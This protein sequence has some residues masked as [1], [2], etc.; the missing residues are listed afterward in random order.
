ML[1]GSE[2]NRFLSNATERLMRD[3]LSENPQ[4]VEKLIPKYDIGCRR[5]SPGDGYLEALQQPNARVCFEAIDEITPRGIRTSSGE[6]DL[7]LIVCATGF[8]TSFIP[9]WEFLGRNGRRLDKEWKA[10]PQAYFSI[11]AAAAPNYFMFAGPNSPIGHGSVPQML[12]WSADY[13][14]KWVQKIAREDIK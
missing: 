10:L 13:I 1:T 8:D 5:L 14:L 2:L 11:C 12:A 7:D 6:E 4:L 9:R 3:R